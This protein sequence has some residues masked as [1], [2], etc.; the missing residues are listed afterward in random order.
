MCKYAKMERFEQGHIVPLERMTIQGRGV[1]KVR[2]LGGKCIKRDSG[3]QLRA[4]G[5]WR[6]IRSLGELYKVVCS[7]RC[8]ICFLF[9]FQSISSKTDVL[10]SFVLTEPCF[11]SWRRASSPGPMTPGLQINKIQ[12]IFSCFLFPPFPF[13]STST[14]LSSRLVLLFIQLLL[15][16]L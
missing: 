12:T 15:Q 2:D 3:G 6:M 16:K 13:S 9:A 7:L 10:Y 11:Q 8:N 14:A 4:R 5:Q 1:R